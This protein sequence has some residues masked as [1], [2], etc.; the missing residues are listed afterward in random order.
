MSVQGTDFTSWIK[1]TL[2]LEYF[3]KEAVSDRIG[4]WSHI[5]STSYFENYFAS[6]EPRERGRWHATACA[7][8][9]LDGLKAHDA[10]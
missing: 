10:K 7:E 8:A 2:R 4:L 1:N 5:D 3:L 9:L 6:Q